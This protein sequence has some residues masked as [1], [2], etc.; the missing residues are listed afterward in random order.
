MSFKV[1]DDGRQSSS[2][3]DSDSSTVIWSSDEEEDD[4]GEPAKKKRRMDKNGDKNGVVGKAELDAKEEKKRL[5]AGMSKEEWLA[6]RD[7]QKKKKPEKKDEKDMTPEEKEKHAE[8][9]KRAAAKKRVKMH[10][11]KGG[12][13]LCFKFLAGKCELQDCLFDH[14]DIEHFHDDDKRQIVAELSK[15]RNFDPELAKKVQQLN[16]PK[17]KQFDKTGWCSQGDKCRYWHMDNAKVAKWAGF[18]MFCDICVK[19]ISSEDMMQEHLN[20]KMHKG[21]VAAGGRKCGAAALEAG[22]SSGGKS[23]EKGKGKGKKGDGKKGGKKGDGK[24]KGKGK[25]GDGKKG[26]GKK[27][28]NKGGETDGAVDWEAPK[29]EATEGA[30]EE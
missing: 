1:N 13:K 5:K 14:V 26:K 22:G 6:H 8:A 21:N 10:V 24:G 29:A 2:D 9:E 12:S 17:C 28:V 7:E 27:G 18:N 20:S 19:P 3:S 30:A 15:R 4:A 11:R 25:K 23:G 16:I